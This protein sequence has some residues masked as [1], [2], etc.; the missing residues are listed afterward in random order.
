MNTQD[1]NRKTTHSQGHTRKMVLQKLY[2]LAMIAMCIMIVFIAYSGETVE[3]RDVTS[4]ILF[5]PMGFYLLATKN[6]VIY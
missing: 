4:V 5:A 1:V 3:G 6:V 2:G